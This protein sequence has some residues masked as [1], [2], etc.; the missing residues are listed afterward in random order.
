MATYDKRLTPTEEALATDILR[1]LQERLRYEIG[2]TDSVKCTACGTTHGDIE[3][4]ELMTKLLDAV[5][6][7]EKQQ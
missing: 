5:A 1:R 3:R 7:L 4:S 6:Q 2:A